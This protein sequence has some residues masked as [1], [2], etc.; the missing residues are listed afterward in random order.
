MISLRQMAIKVPVGNLSDLHRDV[1]RFS[2]HQQDIDKGRSFLF[3]PFVLDNQSMMVFVR[4][5]HL[6]PEKS[7]A[8]SE[9]DD[10]QAY[11]FNVLV[12][13]VRRSMSGERLINDDDELHLWIKE[14]MHGFDILTMNNT[15]EG[16]FTMERGRNTVKLGAWRT[17]G[18]LL[19]TDKISAMETLRK[20]IGRTRG[21][22]F[23]MIILFPIND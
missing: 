21:F 17:S 14:H 8:F 12:R 18:T 20:G 16:P 3:A 4:G 11:S 7:I 9:V 13:A 2:H 10:G 15:F 1:W 5:E 23:G 19:V 22:G 6:L